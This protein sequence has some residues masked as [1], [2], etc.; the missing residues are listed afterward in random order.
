MQEKRLYDTPRWKKLRRMHL[1]KEPLCRMCQAEGVVRAGVVVDHIKPH[2][3][4][5]KL[6][7]DEKNFQTLCAF[8]HNSIK[9]RI[10]KAEAAGK[11]CDKDGFP[12]NPGH[13]WNT[14]KK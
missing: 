5:P 2:R 10:E 3:G 12:L 7:W 1:A 11:G 14:G 13:W 4:D 9:Q 6:F 8:H